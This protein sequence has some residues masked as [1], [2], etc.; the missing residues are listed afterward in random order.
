MCTPWRSL[1]YYQATSYLRCVL[2]TVVIEPPFHISYR[3]CTRSTYTLYLVNIL[4]EACILI[5]AQDMYNGANKYL[6]FTLKFPLCN[7]TVLLVESSV[8][9]G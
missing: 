5:I 9:A 3:Y 7:V 6:A 2:F 1:L 4:Y 8:A